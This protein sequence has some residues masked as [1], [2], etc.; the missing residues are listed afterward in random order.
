MEHKQALGFVPNTSIEIVLPFGT[1]F[2]VC[3]LNLILVIRSN[4]YA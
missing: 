1:A 2:D 3:D 4:N